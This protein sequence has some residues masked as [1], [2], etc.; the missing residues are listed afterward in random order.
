[1]S[2]IS[3][4]CSA[5]FSEQSKKRFARPE[6]SPELPRPT[7]LHSFNIVVS[8]LGHVGGTA[9]GGHFCGRYSVQYSI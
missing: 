5:F 8:H 2:S 9:R 3:F 1:M 6:E 4:C 7:L